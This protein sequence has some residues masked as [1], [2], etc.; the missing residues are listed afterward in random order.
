MDYW[1]TITSNAFVLSSIKGYRM[2]FQS[3]PPLSYP[4]VHQDAIPRSFTATE[5]LDQEIRD[6]LRKKAIE[7]VLLKQ[8]VSSP[9][10][11]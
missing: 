3:V 9:D 4:S 6:M 2:E 5:G 7:P 10:S 8:R 11:F 1:L